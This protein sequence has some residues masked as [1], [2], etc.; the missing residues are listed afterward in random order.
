MV[1]FELF[2][3]LFHQGTVQ[4]FSIICDDSLWNPK[5]TYQII[6]N[7]IGHNFLHHDFV[8]SSF[9][10]LLEV[11]NGNKNELMTIGGS[12]INRS[13]KIHAPFCKWAKRTHRIKLVGRFFDKISIYVACMTPLDKSSTTTFHSNPKV[14]CP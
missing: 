9:D 3:Y 8:G 14:S 10:P 6:A 1:N 12:T 4:I 13:N 7:K 11:I 5:M 2:T